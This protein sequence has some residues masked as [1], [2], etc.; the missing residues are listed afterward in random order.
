MH[1]GDAEETMPHRRRGKKNSF[2]G[3]LDDLVKHFTEQ[4]SNEQGTDKSA[5]K[6]DRSI[7]DRLFESAWGHS[8]GARR[9]R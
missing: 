8:K 6:D 5:P 9:E 3:H 1:F 4:P 2:G 7:H